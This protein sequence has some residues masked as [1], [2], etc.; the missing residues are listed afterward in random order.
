[1]A[2]FDPR[3]S[4]MRFHVR[5]ISNSDHFFTSLPEGGIAYE[6]T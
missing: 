1:M 3:R 2:F 6:S 4:R 5:T